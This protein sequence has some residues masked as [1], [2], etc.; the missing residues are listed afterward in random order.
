[1]LLCS[2]VPAV[3]LGFQAAATARPADH[4][5]R[6]WRSSRTGARL[7]YSDAFAGLLSSPGAGVHCPAL[8]GGVLAPTFLATLPLAAF[9]TA[10]AFTAGALRGAMLGAPSRPSARL[11]L[12]RRALRHSSGDVQRSSPVQGILAPDLASARSSWGLLRHGDCHRVSAA[13][14]AADGI[15]AGLALGGQLAGSTRLGRSP[16]GRPTR[17]TGGLDRLR[18][19]HRRPAR[20]VAGMLRYGLRRGRAVFGFCSG[21]PGW[22]LTEAEL[23]LDAR[24]A[25]SWSGSNQF[26]AVMLGAGL[27]N[28]GFP[29]D[30]PAG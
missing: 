30:H 7:D 29:D 23:H 14:P 26:G 9:L 13:V 17:T 8:R 21:G 25:R 4:Y 24:Q 5:L 11:A 10:A 28:A 27:Q 20:P 16:A 12:L 19:G 22:K 1:M 2:I 15:F 18:S 3:A 6:G